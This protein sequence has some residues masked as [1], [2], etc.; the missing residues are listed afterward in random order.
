MNGKKY[1]F[2]VMGFGKKT[3]PYTGRNINLDETYEK[4]IQPLFYEEFPNF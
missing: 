3:D 2:V 1:C 4:V